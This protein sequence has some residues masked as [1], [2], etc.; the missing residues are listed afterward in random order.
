MQEAEQLAGCGLFRES[1]APEDSR[2]RCRTAL[3]AN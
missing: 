3:D 1:L 2:V